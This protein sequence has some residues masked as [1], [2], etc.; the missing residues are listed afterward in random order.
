MI[1]ADHPARTKREPLT[2]AAYRCVEC[3]RPW[4]VF[5]VEGEPTDGVDPR[6]CRFCDSETPARRIR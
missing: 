1:P 6:K 5:A 2:E 3:D 4:V